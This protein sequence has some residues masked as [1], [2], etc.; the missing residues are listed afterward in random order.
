MNDAIR[1]N[2]PLCYMYQKCCCVELQ[3]VAGVPGG[4]ATRLVMPP[5]KIRDARRRQLGELLARC[6]HVGL[7]L[8]Q[9]EKTAVVQVC[10]IVCSGLQIQVGKVSRY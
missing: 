2:P 10:Q 7:Q 8:V 9:Q 4:S 3:V 6:R 1:G 5:E